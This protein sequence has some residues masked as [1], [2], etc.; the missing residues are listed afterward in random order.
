MPTSR[1]EGYVTVNEPESK[2]EIVGE[3]RLE[4][5]IGAIALDAILEKD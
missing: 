1:Y 4:Q 5:E 2:E 3:V